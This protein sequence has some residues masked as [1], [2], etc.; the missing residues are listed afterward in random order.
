MIIRAQ[1]SGKTLLFCIIWRFIAID[2][3][4]LHCVELELHRG[5]TGTRLCCTLVHCIVMG[6]L[7]LHCI[8]L[9]WIALDCIGLHW[10]AHWTALHCTGLHWIALDCTALHCDALKKLEAPC[11]AGTVMHRK[12]AGSK[13]TRLTLDEDR[14]HDRMVMMTG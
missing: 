4:L 10:I 3:N 11:S 8:V 2:C 12:P 13:P 7:E 14:H 1:C 9:Y 6:C 5:S